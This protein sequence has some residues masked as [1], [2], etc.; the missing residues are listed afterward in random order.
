MLD[1]APRRA[2]LLGRAISA[3]YVYDRPSFNARHVAV[4]QGETVFSIYRTVESDDKHYNRTWYHIPRGYAHSAS[5]QPVRWQLQQPVLQLPEAGFLGEVTVPWTPARAVPS[6]RAPV[7]HRFYYST[8]HWIE[9]V[10]TDE[11]GQV[12]YKALDDRL[13]KYNWILADHVRPVNDE[14]LTPLSPEVLDK[15]IEIDLERQTMRC[16]ENGTVVLDTLTSTGPFLRTENGKRIWGTPSGEWIVNRKRPTRHMAGGDLAASDGFDLHGVPWVTYFHWWGVSF[17]GTFWH[18]D[19]GR[20]RSHGC[21]N[22]PSDLAKWVFRWT[23][24]HAPLS[25]HETK[26]AGT[27]VVVF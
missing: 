27:Q 1:E 2:E 3:V 4:L 21:I 9:G 25:Q 12:W 20:A 7:E 24:P 19:Y 16:L 22:L 14:E 10:H 26:G 17:H 8:T 5:V 23:M 6:S 18:N 11:Q 13:I 15:R